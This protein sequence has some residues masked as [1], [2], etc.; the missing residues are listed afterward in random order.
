M[1]DNELN[2]IKQSAGNFKSFLI[3]IQ[4]K[5]TILVDLYEDKAWIPYNG[6][7]NG[8]TFDAKSWYENTK[9]S[10]TFV[11]PI[12]NKK[13]C[14]ICGYGITGF[15]KNIDIIELEKDKK[16]FN[17]DNLEKCFKY[18]GTD[19]CGGHNHNYTSFY[20]KVFEKYNKNDKINIL[21]LGIARGS[22]LKA[23]SSLFP[24]STIYG[25]DCMEGCKNLCKNYDNINII[26]GDVV[27]ENLPNLH[28]KDIYFDIIIDDA[29]H[30]PDDIIKAYNIYINYLKNDGIYVIEDLKTNTV[31]DYLL[32]YDN[33]D[34][35]SE[36][37]MEKYIEINNRE[38][39]ENFLFN[40]EKTNKK[41]FY[42]ED[43]SIIAL[44]KQ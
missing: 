43:K 2:D 11:C 36:I 8:P 24:N 31:L 40:L 39:L 21:E 14:E 13:L 10:K 44:K 33:V 6:P 26:I 7:T 12:H 27:D 20:K 25:V 28:F 16:D 34:R 22:S 9:N 30:L 17:L 38:K 15:P 19:K 18:Y 1:N 3:Q 35:L 4:S 37:S 29:S 32:M 41:L 42:S 5:E 23:F